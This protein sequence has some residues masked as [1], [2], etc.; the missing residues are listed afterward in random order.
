MKKIKGN[1]VEKINKWLNEFSNTL[2]DN[3]EYYAFYRAM[4]YSNEEGI[5][6]IQFLCSNEKGMLKSPCLQYD[7]EKGTLA[8]DYSG[9]KFNFTDEKAVIDAI[10]TLIKFL[11]A[12]K[13]PINRILFDTCIY[14]ARIT[15]IYIRDD[16]KHEG[17]VI[18]YCV[19][20][21]HAET[22]YSINDAV[23]SYGLELCSDWA[24]EARVEFQNFIQAGY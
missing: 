6:N 22:N 24:A 19:S 17:E 4:V 12:F 3:C 23:D 15:D 20:K 18:L 9:E 1:T 10:H 2:Q 21:G 11:S 13:Q 5:I 7:S 14:N 16:L 8:Y